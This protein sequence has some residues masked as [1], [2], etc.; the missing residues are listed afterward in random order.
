MAD[1][2]GYEVYP[3]FNSDA[4]KPLDF[5]LSNIANTSREVD[6]AIRGPVVFRTANADSILI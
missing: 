5:V 4:A 2:S 6:M 3:D 1:E